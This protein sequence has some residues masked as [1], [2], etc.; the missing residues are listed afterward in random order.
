MRTPVELRGSR[1][2][3]GSGDRVSRSPHGTRSPA[4]CQSRRTESAT[5][6]AKGGY[7]TRDPNAAQKHAGP[8]FAYRPHQN[9]PA[10]KFPCF[11]PDHS[12]S[13]PYPFAPPAAPGP[14]KSRPGGRRRFHFGRS[15]A[16][17][18]SA[19]PIRHKFA[20]ARRD[21]SAALVAGEHVLLV[22]PPGT[23]KSLLL[24]AVARFLDGRRFACLLTKFTRPD[25]LYGPVSLAGLPRGPV[26]PRHRRPT[27]RRRP[28]GGRRRPEAGPRGGVRRRRRPGRRRQPQHDRP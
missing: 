6:A 21:L 23:A 9:S 2:V 17:D 19:D 7:F 12:P 4:S 16:T 11:R 10:A 20:Q 27:E 5:W 28:R 1:F 3:A 8:A 26:R 18:P 22:G 15:P 14:P 25:E 13:V 24:D